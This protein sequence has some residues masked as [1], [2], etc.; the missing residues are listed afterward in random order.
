[1]GEF[2]DRMKMYENKER[3]IP[4]LPIVIRLDGKKFSKWT[5]GLNRPYDDRMS[6]LMSETTR[7]LV[8]ETNAKI[9]YTQSDEI[10]LVLYSDNHKSSVFFDGKKQKII[11]VVSSL[12]TGIFNNLRND[13]IPEKKKLAYF[14]CRAYNVPTKQEAANAVLWREQDATKNSI[15]M[16]GHHYFSHNDLHKLTTNH[17]QEK[18]WKDADVNCDEY[19]DFFKRGVFYQRKS[20]IRKFTDVEMINLPKNHNALS[21]KNLTVTRSDIIKTNMPSFGKVINRV[22][23][24]FDGEEPKTLEI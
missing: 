16:A 15:Q 11:S 6:S 14:D 18:L 22:G 4:L 3:F 9:G 19:P 17:I 1:M 13:Y 7:L 5:K 20:I 10:T 2:G 12:C 8:K 21:D 24:I 23:V